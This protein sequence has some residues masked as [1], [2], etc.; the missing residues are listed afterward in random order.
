MNIGVQIK[1]GRYISKNIFSIFKEEGQ[2][3]CEKKCK[4]WMDVY[5]QY[6]LNMIIP[7][8]AYSILSWIIN[9]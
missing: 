4:L 1:M 5:V 3:G 8:R 9:F 7:L 6:S 2:K